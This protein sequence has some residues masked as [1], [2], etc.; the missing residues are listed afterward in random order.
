MINEAGNFP[1][2]AF[3]E[4]LRPLVGEMPEYAELQ[5]ERVE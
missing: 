5:F 1:S 4:Y 2:E 3:L